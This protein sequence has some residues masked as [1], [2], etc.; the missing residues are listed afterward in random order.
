[1]M[2]YLDEGTIIKSS[3]DDD[4]YPQGT[5]CSEVDDTDNKQCLALSVLQ[6]RNSGII[7]S[8]LYS[9]LLCMQYETC[10]SYE[11]YIHCTACMIDEG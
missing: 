7:Y 1:M 6:P 9:D 10:M 5:Q 3:D 2:H 11:H 4:I 8:H